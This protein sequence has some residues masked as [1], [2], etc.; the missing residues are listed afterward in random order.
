MPAGQVV[1]NPGGLI[2]EPF[3]GTPGGSNLALPQSQLDDTEAR[4]IQDG[5]VDYPGLTRRRGPVRKVTGIATIPR[6]GSGL[7]MTLN[8]QGIDKYGVL[9]GDVSNGYFSVLSDDL[10][11]VV[12]LTWP[13]PLPTTP[14]SAP[15]RIVDAKPALG[16]GLWLGISSAYDAADPNQG[17]ALWMGAN[18]VNYS[19]TIK[20]ARGSANVTLPSGA[21]ANVVIGHW[22]FADTDEG[23]TQALVG[24]VK[25]INS[26]T[27]VTL[28]ETSP[29]NVGQSP[30]VFK[31][32]TFQALRGFQPKVVT[33]RITV[34]ST[35]TKVI[36]GATKFLSQS[37]DTGTWQLY[38]AKDMTFI[39]KVTS[40]E[41]EFA[42]TLTA[43]AAVAMAED[44]YIALRADAD[45]NISTTGNKNKVGFL[46]A[47]YAG[48]QWYANNGSQLDKTVRVW[49]SDTNDPEAVDLAEF[50]GDWDEVT[51]SSTVNEAIRAIAPA[52]NGLLVFKENESFIITGNSPNT[53]SPKKLED[54]GALSGMSVQQFGGGVIWAGREGIHFFDGIQ[55]TN[56]VADK[57]GD[58]WKN[59]IRTYDPNFYR[60]W[61]MMNRDHYILFVESLSPTVVPV[62]GVISQSI[63]KYTFVINMITR[64]V[65][66]MT[67][68][69][70]RGAVTLPASAGRHTWYLVNGRT[71]GE[72]TDHAF[73]SEGD[74]LFNEEGTD[75]IASGSEAVIGA[76]TV[77]IASPAVFS[78]AAHGLVV[79][80][81]LYFTTTGALPTG[82]SLATPYY[83][84]SAGLDA[85]HFEVSATLGGSAV[86]TSGTQ[87]G[88][89]TVARAWSVKGPDF[90]WESKKFNAGDPTRLKKFKQIMLHYLVQGGNI[91][92]DTVIGL[93][94]FGQTLV[95]NF[96]PS[97][98]TWDGLAQKV[99]TW[100]A[101]K[102]QFA[103]WS[104]LV[105]GVF[106]PKRVKFQR[107]S[108]HLS[109]RLWQSNPDIV[110]LQIG[111]FNI[112]Y[113][114]KRQ[115]RV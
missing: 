52:N 113:K 57:L 71:P 89:H 73:I 53:F 56:L 65:T 114:Q 99:G 38:R 103:T 22:L 21:N 15:Y 5:L 64:A 36:G 77:T 104:D 87:S 100:D 67:N 17:L 79:G 76:F 41:S 39:G 14:P 111:A 11:S 101:V 12:D 34:D 9:N 32:A 92:V 40:V 54:D 8:P 58:Y 80:D 75:P 78:S 102:A 13:H 46:N 44:S 10:T 4:Y 85:D 96:P 6:K 66:F 50:D 16:G 91:N 51:S 45:V 25:S 29:Y 105:Q 115:G 35:S 62:K 82:L 33:G 59:T 90:F 60:M 43:N 88:A 69:D 23:Y 47:T 70:L 108:Q 106:K 97:V 37:L 30:S 98:L 2:T 27:S 84:I 95:G 42:L 26:D 3:N 61:S 18:R 107:D 83:V 28:S 63:T 109:F 49:F 110:R 72:A 55:A 94:N 112:A 86:N 24:L 7:V 68:V 74:A 19:G 31:T 1:G 20:V 93:N 48:R 81:A